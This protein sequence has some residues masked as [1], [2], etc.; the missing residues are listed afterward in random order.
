M[1]SAMY[2]LTDPNKQN[3]PTRRYQIREKIILFAD[4]FIIKDEMGQDAGMIKIEQGFPHL[5]PTYNILSARH[6]DFGRQLGVLK[7]QFELLFHKKFNIDSVY[8][9]Y[10]LESLDISAHSFILTKNGRIV[11]TISKT[12]FST[13]DTYGVEIAADEDQAFILAIVIVLDQIL[14]NNYNGSN[15]SFQ[16]GSTNRNSNTFKLNF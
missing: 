4:N 11:A 15:R 2:P 14:Y 1:A 5:H 13:S 3:I 12:Y 7:Q 10:C 16:L 9:Q 8:G 6:G